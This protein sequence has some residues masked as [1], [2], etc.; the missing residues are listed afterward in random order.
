M[1]ENVLSEVFCFCLHGIHSC[2]S[3]FLFIVNI[4]LMVIANI[5]LRLLFSQPLSALSVLA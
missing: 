5:S 2:H 3:R 4:C 1:G